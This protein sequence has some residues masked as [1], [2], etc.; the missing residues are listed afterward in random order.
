[1]NDVLI[2]QVGGS[3]RYTVDFTNELPSTSPETTV[4]AVAWS[5]SP[6]EGSPTTVA[7]SAQTDDLS[8]GKS[9]IQVSGGVHD[10]HYVLQAIAT[11][12]GGETIPK[13]VKLVA[14]DG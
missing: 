10:H 5:I 3:L 12:S 1:M 8:N 9:T 14:I 6:D 13:D 7:L 4:S 2:L 11:T